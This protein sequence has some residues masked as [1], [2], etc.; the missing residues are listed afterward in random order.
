MRIAVIGDFHIQKS[1]LELTEAAMEDLAACNPDLVVP[2]GD[3]GSN[4]QIGGVE[5]LHQAYHYLRHISSPLRPILGNHDLQRESGA[6]KQMKGTIE[7]AFLELYGL[8]SA[9]GVIEQ[10]DYRLFFISTEPQP[11]ESCYQVQECFVSDEQFDWFQKALAEKPGIPCII[12]THAPPIGC[13]L[14]TVPAVHVRATNAYLDQNHD[15]YRWLKLIQTTPEIVAWFSAHYHLGHGHPDSSSFKYGTRFFTTGVHGTV[16]R[17]GHRQSR[18]IN[19]EKDK[20]EIFTMDHDSRKLHLVADWSGG[21]LSGLVEDKQKLLREPAASSDEEDELRCLYSCSVGTAATI[22]KQIRSITPNRSLILTDDGY[23]WE[24]DPAVDAVLGSLH[25]GTP[26]IGIAVSEDGVWRAWNDLLLRSD[27]NDLGRFQRDASVETPGPRLT[28]DTNI[29]CLCSRSGGGVWVGCEDRLY[30][31]WS[32]DSTSAAGSNLRPVLTL[33][34][35][36]IAQ[37]FEYD[38]GLILLTENRQLYRWDR[39]QPPILECAHVYAWDTHGQEEAG[40]IKESGK[41]HLVYKDSIGIWKKALIQNQSLDP[42]CT[43]VVCLGQRT[44]LLLINGQAILWNVDE[45][46]L[47]YLET[48]SAN[49]T[50]ISRNSKSAPSTFCLSLDSGGNGLPQLQIWHYKR[51]C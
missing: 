3:F 21:S 12:F 14:R 47:L 33:H 32:D 20:F 16:T 34:E 28:F 15:P 26:L 23:L 2:L 4:D 51:S 36:K 42:A 44:S 43:D 46:Q 38:G 30:E 35:K 25:L 1:E 19:V 7:K 6:G 40:I 9:Y 24:A 18:I 17:D 5:G 50:A 37:L 39:K 31:I 10:E 29:T 27:T 22:L 13:G 11:P 45:E 8:E 49:V 48:G 41:V